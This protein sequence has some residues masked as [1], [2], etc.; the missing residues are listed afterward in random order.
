MAS[1]S[2]II[3]PEKLPYE[4]GKEIDN[5]KVYEFLAEECRQ[6]ADL[7]AEFGKGVLS[8]TD[9]DEFWKQLSEKLDC[10]RICEE[11][12]HPMIEGYVFD[13]CNTYCSDECLHKHVSEEE[14]NTLYN[15]G[16]GNTYWTAWYE[17]SLTFKNRIINA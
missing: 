1:T 9:D 13:G 8:H 6:N 16:E 3:V 10:F 15:D 7:W 2:I 5:S 12:G 17:D 4:F 11:C 14:F